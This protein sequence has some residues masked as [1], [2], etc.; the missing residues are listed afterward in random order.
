M[1][2]LQTVTTLAAVALLC[3]TTAASTD[4][5]PA[6]VIVMWSG[7]MDSI[8]A[9]W[10]LCDGQNGTPDLSNRFVLGAGTPEYLGSTGGSH[11]HRHRAGD[12]THPIDPPATRLRPLPGYR[13]YERIRSQS[14]YYMLPGQ[15][16]DLKPFTSGPSTR[17]P[18]SAQHLPPYYKIAF[19]MKL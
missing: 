10:A 3:L 6:G 4:E 9:G 16:F 1:S 11:S 15:T 2:A 14:R 19:I 12:H 17:A 18:D 7:P 8:P 13:G 5:L